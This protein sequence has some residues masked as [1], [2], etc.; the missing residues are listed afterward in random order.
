MKILL[1][2]RFLSIFYWLEFGPTPNPKSEKILTI[3]TKIIEAA[4]WSAGVIQR[5]LKNSFVKARLQR[6]EHNSWHGFVNCKFFNKISFKIKIF[7]NFLQSEFRLWKICPQISENLRKRFRFSFC[8][9]EEKQ[10]STL[11]PTTITST[12][13]LAC[14]SNKSSTMADAFLF[15]KLLTVFGNFFFVVS[16]QI[17]DFYFYFPSR[18]NWSPPS[19]SSLAFYFL[20]LE[21]T[22]KF[23]STPQ[24]PQ[25]VLSSSRLDYCWLESPYLRFLFSVYAAPV[26]KVASS[27][28]LYL[29]F[30]HSINSFLPLIE[31]K[32]KKV[33]L[34]SYCYCLGPNWTHR[35][36][37]LWTSS[38]SPNAWWRLGSTRRHRQKSYSKGGSIFPTFC[39][40]FSL[41]KFIWSFSTSSNAVV[42][43]TRLM[44]LDL[45][46]QLWFVI[47]LPPSLRTNYSFNIL[48]CQ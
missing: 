47:L 17:Q 29:S 19:Y 11:F 28:L 35:R 23:R 37:V 33:H 2:V 22:S 16:D 34:C 21:S 12:S 40:R 15:Y 18:K 1:M 3:N 24:W 25:R 13:N 10:Q 14:H 4:I 20:G 43:P 41:P 26:E 6:S 44:L 39:I 48:F 9:K 32:K 38:S 31:K 30:F 36:W 27:L 45:F 42:L 46:A 8:Q 5:D 7:L